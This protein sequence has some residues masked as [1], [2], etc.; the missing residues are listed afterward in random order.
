MTPRT[1]NL[2]SAIMQ[3]MDKESTSEND[4]E[5][6]NDIMVDILDACKMGDL[7]IVDSMGIGKVAVHA[8]YGIRS[9]IEKPR[10]WIGTQSFGEFPN[11]RSIAMMSVDPNTDKPTRFLIAE[12]NAAGDLVWAATLP[13][14]KGDKP[15]ILNPENG[16]DSLY[17][18][19]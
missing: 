12:Y 8:N 11:Y 13:T 5:M 15:T 6:F 9:W 17:A 4:R 14:S 16:I 7:P 18:I 10:K 3:L 1:R 19:C 2:F